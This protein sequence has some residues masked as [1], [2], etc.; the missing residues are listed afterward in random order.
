MSIIITNV[1]KHDDL[2]G[3]NDYVVSI[4]QREVGRFQHIRKE[5]LAACL[6]RAAHAVEEARD[7][8]IMRAALASIE[9]DS[10]GEGK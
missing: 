4:N 6:R 9:Q 7:D 2:V 10:D 3:M 8:L 1:S 5:G